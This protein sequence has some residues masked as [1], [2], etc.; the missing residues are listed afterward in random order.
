MLLAPPNLSTTLLT[1]GPLL[2]SNAELLPDLGVVGLLAPV[3]R[4]Q[5]AGLVVVP[6][7]QNAG[8]K[9]NEFQVK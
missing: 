8:L 3:L 1:N 2:F 5:V 9:K 6:G 4:H 7:D